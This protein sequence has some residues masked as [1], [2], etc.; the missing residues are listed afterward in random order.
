[1]RWKSKSWTLIGVLL[2][3]IPGVTTVMKATAA[4]QPTSGAAI[5]GTQITD[6]VY[7]ADGKP[8]MGTLIVSWQA[9]TTAGGQAVPSGTTSA[10]IGMER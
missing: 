9:F 7:R 5:A 4:A 3:A 2:L 8:A 1:M 6:T 10:P